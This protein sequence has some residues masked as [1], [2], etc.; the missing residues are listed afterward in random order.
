MLL[1]KDIV[2]LVVELGLLQNM[3]VLGQVWDGR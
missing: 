1:S 3:Q 2:V